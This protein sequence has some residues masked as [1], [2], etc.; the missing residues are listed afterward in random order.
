MTDLQKLEL[1]DLK[2]I[3]LWMIRTIEKDNTAKYRIS[4]VWDFVKLPSEAVAIWQQQLGFEKRLK[5]SD[6]ADMFF[7]PTNEPLKQ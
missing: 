3:S 1:V 6:E 4:T 5:T 7:S 2:Y